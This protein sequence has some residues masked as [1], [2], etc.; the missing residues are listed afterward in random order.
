VKIVLGTSLFTY[1]TMTVFYI[2][3]R[4]HLD[5]GSSPRDWAFLFGPIS[6]LCC[7]RDPLL[8][9]ELERNFLLTTAIFWA[10]WVAALLAWRRN[11]IAGTILVLSC[12][13]FWLWNGM[14]V[15]AGS[16]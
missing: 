10:L 14:V 15:S 16:V 13:A 11:R 3:W 9:T 7:T 6:W 1:L 2:S 12:V 5:F 8:F 4:V